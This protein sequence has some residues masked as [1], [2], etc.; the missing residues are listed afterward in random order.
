MT[1]TILVVDD[2]PLFRQ[3]LVLASSNVFPD[4]LI[5]ESGTLDHAIKTVQSAKNLDL[6]L[7][8]LKLPGALGYSGVAM[9]HAEVPKV[10]ILV[11]SSADPDRA[12][13]EA[14]RFGAVGFISKD[15]A[16][17]VIE[18][19]LR[20]AASANGADI[21]HEEMDNSSPAT[22]K[23]DKEVDNMAGKV[24]LLT[25]MQLKVLLG[26]LTGRLNKQIAFDLGI[27][28]ATVKAHLTAIFKKLDVGN[29]TQAALAA[30]ALGIGVE[31]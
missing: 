10:P 6:I 13:I 29:R 12:S 3:A 23:I 20:K 30:R 24:A 8:D 4:A 2:H 15:S 5:I 28:E 22:F 25:P 27:S 9:I 14:R 1:R 31:L 16:L 11:V 26:I 7:L 21:V 19:A 17:D 18:E